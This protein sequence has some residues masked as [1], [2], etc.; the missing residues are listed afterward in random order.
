MRTIHMITSR[1]SAH[2]LEVLHALSG[3][4]SRAVCIVPMTAGAPPLLSL[5]VELNVRMLA[6]SRPE[7]IAGLGECL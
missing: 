4:H 7:E 3:R 1:P 2:L 6:I 5:A